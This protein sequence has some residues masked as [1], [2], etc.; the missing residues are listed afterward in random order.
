[1][2]DPREVLE[3]FRDHAAGG[4]GSHMLVSPAHAMSLV[5]LVGDMVRGS[6]EARTIAA[7]ALGI[8]VAGEEQ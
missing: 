6:D 4:P 8:D 5:V 1:M 2:T 3:A 7:G